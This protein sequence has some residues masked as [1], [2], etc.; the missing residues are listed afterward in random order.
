VR[1]VLDLASDDARFV[2]GIAMLGGGG[3][4]ITWG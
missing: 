3:F 2:T 4:S 1:S